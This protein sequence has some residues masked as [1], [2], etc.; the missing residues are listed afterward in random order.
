MRAF[1]AAVSKINKSYCRENIRIFNGGYITQK[2]SVAQFAVNG[3]KSFI[4]L[5]TPF[6]YGCRSNSPK[7]PSNETIREMVAKHGSVPK[8][9]NALGLT[10][11]AVRYRLRNDDFEL[12]LKQ[13]SL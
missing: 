3:V 10:Y 2:D 11:E 9:A 12:R 5:V 6:D 4:D 1:K 13:H 8:A 7:I